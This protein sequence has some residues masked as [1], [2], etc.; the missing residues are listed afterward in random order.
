MNIS[1]NLEKTKQIQLYSQGKAGDGYQR[2][3]V[4][5]SNGALLI[6]ICFGYPLIHHYITTV[7]GAKWGS[8]K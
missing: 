4:T 5:N 2:G 8:P 1:E 6:Q 7:R 3:G